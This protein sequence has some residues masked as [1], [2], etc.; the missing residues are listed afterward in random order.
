MERGV[1]TSYSIHYTKLYELLTAGALVLFTG[2]SASDT[3]A[4]LIDTS[5]QQLGSVLLE[6]YVFPFEVTGILLIA[7]IIGVAIF[8]LRKKRGAAA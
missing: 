1:I 7:A 6:T 8:T 5:P 3:T 4:A 2:Q